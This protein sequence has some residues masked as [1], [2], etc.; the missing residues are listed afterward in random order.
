MTPAAP[1]ETSSNS[2]MINNSASANQTPGLTQT[3]LFVTHAVL[4]Y[5]IAWV[6]PLKKTDQ[7][8]ALTAQ[9]VTIGMDHFVFTVITAILTVL[10]VLRMETLVL[11]ASEAPTWTQESA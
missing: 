3:K 2:P 7:Q 9:K 5:L 6:V 10:N 4:F 8:N 11:N 1:T